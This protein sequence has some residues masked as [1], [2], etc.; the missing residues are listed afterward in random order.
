MPQPAAVAAIGNRSETSRTRKPRARV[1][2]RATAG[3]SVSRSGRRWPLVFRLFA[4]R[5]RQNICSL[6]SGRRFL[7]VP[8]NVR[9]N[10]EK[11]PGELPIALPDPPFEHD[12]K[13]FTR[14]HLLCST[15]KSSQGTGTSLVTRSTPR[16]EF[17]WP[18][19][20]LGCSTHTARAILEPS[21]SWSHNSPRH[22]V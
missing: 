12:G 21:F 6:L 4:A 19:Y 13:S 9:R 20:R 10:F 7:R 14:Y 5:S 22:C 11:I 3:E 15:G 17:S 8:G 16:L 1:S 18:A 2:F